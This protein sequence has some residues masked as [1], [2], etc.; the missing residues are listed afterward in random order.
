MLQEKLGHIKAV[1]LLKEAINQNPDYFLAWIYLTATYSQM[2]REE[3]ARA[4]AS[5]VERFNPRFVVERYAKRLPYKNQDHIKTL[6]VA[7]H[8]A[9]LK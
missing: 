3:E 9:G 8:K 4:A 1:E 6:I 2:G 7:L 5:K